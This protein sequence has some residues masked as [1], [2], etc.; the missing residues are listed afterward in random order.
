MSE[1]TIR[2][3]D[4]MH[5][6][7][8]ERRMLRAALPWTAGVYARAIVMPNTEAGILSAADIGA[9][10]NAIRHECPED[11]PAANFEP[12][13]TIKL[14]AATT[15]EVIEAARAERAVAAKLYPAGTTTGSHG[16]VSD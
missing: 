7:L 9:Y 15:P 16:G 12:L 8:R 6:H 5:V 3:P 11:G 1:L 10:R 4:N 2:R 14:T 13:M